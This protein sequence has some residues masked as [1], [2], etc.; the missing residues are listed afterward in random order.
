MIVQVIFKK[1]ISSSASERQII[2]TDGG[3]VALGRCVGSRCSPPDLHQPQNPAGSRLRCQGGG[4]KDSITCVLDLRSSWCV[5]FLQTEDYLKRK[6][7]S[8]P[9]RSELVRMHILEG[10]LQFGNGSSPCPH[11]FYCALPTFLL[12]SFLS[13]PFLL[14]VGK[15]SLSTAKQQPCDSHL[16]SGNSQSSTT[17]FSLVGL[18]SSP[19]AI[20]WPQILSSLG[21]KV[22]FPEFSKSAVIFYFHSLFIPYSFSI[23]VSTCDTQ[24]S[25]SQ[26]CST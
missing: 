9:E 3:G 4:Y 19:L 15:S 21:M 20:W 1:Y 17:P 13:L 10:V 2:L 16:G 24:V 14:T 12:P 11:C 23:H 25:S 22:L 18:S 26:M 8:R 6:I 7:R 5:F